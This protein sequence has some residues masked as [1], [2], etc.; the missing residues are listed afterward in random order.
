M[1]RSTGITGHDPIAVPS[2]RS[3]RCWRRGGCRHPPRALAKGKCAFSAGATVEAVPD[4]V[5]V[6][7]GV[8]NR[9][10]SPPDALDQNSAIARKIIDFSKSFG[11]G[12]RDIQTT[13]RQPRSELQ[14]RSRP[15]REQRDRNPTATPRATWSTSSLA[16]SRVW[17]RSCAKSSIKG[18][19]ISPACISGCR[20]SRNCRTRR[21]RKR[22]K[23]R[24]GK[25]R[26]LHRPPM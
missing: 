2:S 9:A 10:P 21:G 25:R 15:Q 26:D 17:E 11:V 19:P 8:S 3:S 22:S 23:M 1:W 6:Q 7:V 14:D 5:T 4:Y 18:R 24:C 12:E 20:M 13:T 16:T